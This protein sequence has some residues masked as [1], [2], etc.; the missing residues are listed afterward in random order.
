VFGRQQRLPPVADADRW[1][2]SKT[3]ELE[4]DQPNGEFDGLEQLL[5]L[6]EPSGKH[7]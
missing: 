5:L 4:D 6:T 3:M 2:C 7:M 1:P